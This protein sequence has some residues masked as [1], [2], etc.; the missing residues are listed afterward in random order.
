MRHKTGVDRTQTTQFPQV[1]DDFVSENNPVRFIY[2]FVDSLAM[3]QVAAKNLSIIEPGR[4]NHVSYELNAHQAPTWI[5]GSR[6]P[7]T[8]S[9]P[10]RVAS[11]RC[12]TGVPS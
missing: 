6:A 3:A 1:V 7:R 4:A 9:G 2:A 12:E 11:K 8:M 5:G 10:S